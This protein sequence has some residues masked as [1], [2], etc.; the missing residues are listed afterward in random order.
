[1]LR[2]GLR[3][4]VPFLAG[5]LLLQPCCHKADAVVPRGAV[6]SVDSAVN[7]TTEP[8][9]K[10]TGTLQTWGAGGKGLASPRGVGELEVL[11]AGAQVGWR[12]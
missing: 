3:A 7:H 9:S 1:M 6:Q 11:G 2:T 5:Y 8:N 12:L 4:V 10:R